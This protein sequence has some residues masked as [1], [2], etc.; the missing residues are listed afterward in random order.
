M[1]DTIPYSSLVWVSEEQD[2]TNGTNRSE[3]LSVLSRGN[4]VSHLLLQ[5]VQKTSD[6]HAESGRFIKNSR[7]YHLPYPSPN[8]KCSIIV[9]FLGA[10]N[11]TFNLKTQ[12]F[13]FFPSCSKTLCPITHFQHTQTTGPWS[14]FQK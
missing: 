10:V 5:L 7:V 12:P 13:Y 4:S 11:A 14:C 9:M 6:E 3:G 1:N 2:G 8:L